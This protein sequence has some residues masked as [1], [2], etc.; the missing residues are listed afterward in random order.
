MSLSILKQTGSSME[1]TSPTKEQIYYPS[2]YA[3]GRVS[4]MNRQGPP[5]SE[6][7]H[8]LKR[9]RREHIYEVPYPRWSEEEEAYSHIMESA[10]TPTA[11]IYQTPRKAGISAKV[12]CGS[13]TQLSVDGRRMS[14]EGRH[15]TTGYKPSSLA[16]DGHSADDSDSEGNTYAFQSNGNGNY[17][18]HQEMSEAECDRDQHTRAA[19]RLE[20][21]G[22]HVSTGYS[23]T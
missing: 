19:K 10:V 3:L 16:S 5:E 11:N 13:N 20:A 4:G 9:T 2:P 1:G 17:I 23:V 6:S 15:H 22:I 21:L 18:E 12:S 8:T 7:V 14:R